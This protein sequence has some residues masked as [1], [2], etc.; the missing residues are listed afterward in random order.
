MNKKLWLYRL[1]AVALLVVLGGVMMVIGRGHTVYFD[2]K[3]LEVEGQEYP[4]FYR[5]EI[6]VGGARVAKL[7]KRERGMATVMGQKFSFEVVLTKNKGDE[8][9][10]IPVTLELPYGL[11]GIVINLPGYF[12][13]LPEEAWKSEFVPLV[14][15]EE[16]SEEIPTGDEFDIGGDL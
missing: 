12:A 7:S 10:T 9:Q 4:A 8:P 3:T 16:V 13:E 5:T 6:N 2:N 14:V 1:L 11:D 15:Q